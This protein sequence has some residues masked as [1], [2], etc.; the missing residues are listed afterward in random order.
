MLRRMTLS[1]AALLGVLLLTRPV[2]AQ[3]INTLLFK[4][5]LDLRN[6]TMGITQTLTKL[7]VT[8]NN[9][10]TTSTE[11]AVLQNTTASTAGATIQ[12]SPRLRERSTTYNSISTLSETQDWTIQITPS[13]MTG[14][15][16]SVLH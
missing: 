15:T 2:F 16:T 1:A 5:L 9:L 14:T 6:G 12:V 3:D 4:F 11:G 10:G 7:T 8:T 13:T